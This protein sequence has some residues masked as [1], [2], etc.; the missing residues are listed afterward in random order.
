MGANLAHDGAQRVEGAAVSVRAG[1]RPALCLKREK[2]RLSAAQP[3]RQAPRRAC[4]RFLMVHTGYVKPSATMPEEGVQE[5]ARQRQRQRRAPPNAL[6]LRTRAP[7]DRD[8]AR[9]RRDTRAAE[10]SA[11]RAWRL[12]TRRER[13]CCDAPPRPL[14]AISRYSS[15]DSTGTGGASAPMAAAED[16]R[17]WQLS[18]HHCGGSAAAGGASAAWRHHAERGRRRGG[19][20]ASVRALAG[21]AVRGA[22]DPASATTRRRRQLI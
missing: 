19:R 6:Q 5:R 2:P 10:R 3:L 1:A 18:E 21:G 20:D 11:A 14:A 12:A 16:G 22:R 9:A 4:M 15:A 17:C 13:S 8:A 7:C